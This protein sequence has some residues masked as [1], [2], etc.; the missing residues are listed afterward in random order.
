[1]LMLLPSIVFFTI[2]PPV[3]MPEGLSAAPA[4]FTVLEQIGQAGSFGILVLSKDHFRLHK[5]NIWA[6]AMLNCIVI[7]YGLW[8]RYIL[9]GKEF[10]SLWTPFLFVPIPLAIIPVGAFGFAALWGR[11]RWLGAAT[12]ILAVGHITVT[13]MSYAQIR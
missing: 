10:S 6:V 7:H 2:F 11:S 5:V 3:N 1:M 12:M 13:W 4:V 8:L 9:A